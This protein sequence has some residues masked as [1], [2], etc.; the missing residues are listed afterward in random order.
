MKRALITGVNGMDGSYLA[1]FLL[2]QGYDVYGME[3]RTSSPNRINTSHLEGKITFFSGCL[4]H[5]TDTHMSDE[6]RITIAMDLSLIP[7]DN[8]IKIKVS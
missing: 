3:R 1:D 4:P 2:V 5:Y 6:E 7:E 8:F